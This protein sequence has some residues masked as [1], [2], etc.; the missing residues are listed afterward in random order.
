MSASVKGGVKGVGRAGNSMLLWMAGADPTILADC[1]PMERHETRKLA[2]QGSLVLIPAAFAAGSMTYVASTLCGNLTL[3]AIVGAI[4]GLIVLSIDRYIVS[5]LH[6]AQRGVRDIVRNYDRVDETVS[7]KR[8]SRRM[9]LLPLISRVTFTVVLGVVVSDPIVLLINSKTINA[10]LNANKEAGV[11][12]LLKGAE[13][14]K[15]N[16]VRSSGLQSAT[17]ALAAEEARSQCL[18]TLLSDEQ[19]GVVAKLSCGSSSGVVSQ[20]PNYRSD[21]ARKEHV[22]NV[23][24]P[25]LQQRVAALTDSVN[26]QRA[27]ID[28]RTTSQINQFVAT[29]SNDYPA[30]LE[31][32]QKVASVHPAIYVLQVFL[33][34]FFFSIDLT[35]LFLKLSTPAGIY[36]VV[37]D[38]KNEEAIV[39]ALVSKERRMAA[40]TSKDV[41]KAQISALAAEMEMTSL[42]KAVRAIAQSQMDASEIIL[43][44]STN[45]KDGETIAS[46]ARLGSTAAEAILNAG[47]RLVS[48]SSNT[49]E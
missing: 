13:L 45:A 16:L 36:E 39:D 43:S 4:F 10:Q 3:S 21:L 46:L 28:R 11:T 30:R 33:F 26:Q 41:S 5:T 29:F 27:T 40:L 25:S 42:I 47:T 35:A 20:G 2:A 31:A 48:T 23:I 18:G 8:L 1:G 22:D 37:L 9:P 17:S 24:I 44:Y 19:S 7:W 49:V 14:Q 38:S 32:L 15:T 12:S 6:K 34:L